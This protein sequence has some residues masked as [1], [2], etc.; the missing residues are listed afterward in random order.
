ME[1][2]L[3]RTDERNQL[4]R[5]VEWL[6]ESFEAI[7]TKMM[8]SFSAAIYVVG[9]QPPAWATADYSN[10][11]PY[12]RQDLLL[13][14]QV[15]SEFHQARTHL[16]GMLFFFILAETDHVAG[17]VDGLHGQAEALQFLDQHAE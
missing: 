7:R 12:T 11:P 17:L 9:L 13:T 5:L 16:R 2:T 10:T 3:E 1:K 14:Y 4:T 15:F 8:A 6:T